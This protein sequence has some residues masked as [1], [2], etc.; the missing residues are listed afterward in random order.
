MKTAPT[1][2]LSDDERKNSDCL[3]AGTQHARAFGV[4]GEDRFGS[5]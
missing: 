3:V 1:I 5:C 2:V 4:A